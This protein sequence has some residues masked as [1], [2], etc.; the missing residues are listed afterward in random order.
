MLPVMQEA[1]TG[2]PK[3]NWFKIS[4]LL[5]CGVL[6]S[7]VH[8]I[9]AQL[10]LPQ[11]YSGQVNVSG[12]LMSEKLDGVRGYWDGKQL[13]S[14]NGNVFYPP[15]AFIHDLPPFSLEGEL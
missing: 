1:C 7:A 15:A 2:A 3:T 11:V 12:W 9:A 13:L 10:M 14:K 5:C 6:L 4:L 8:T